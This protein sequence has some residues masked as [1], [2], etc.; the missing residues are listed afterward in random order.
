MDGHSS[1]LSLP[2]SEFC[3]DNDIVLIAL[4]PNSTHIL[5]PMDVAVFHSLKNAW[6]KKVHDWRMQNNGRRLKRCEFGPLLEDCILV[7]LKPETIQHGFRACGLFPFNPDAVNYSKLIKSSSSNNTTNVNTPSTNFPIQ[8]SP[9]T[10]TTKNSDQIVKYLEEWAGS[11]KIR[12]F[13]KCDGDWIGDVK[14]TNLYL[15]WKTVNSS[16]TTSENTNDNNF[17]LGNST[18]EA[19]F[20]DNLSDIN[21]DWS[22]V[23]DEDFIQFD[24]QKDGFLEYSSQVNNLTTKIGSTPDSQQQSVT[25]SD[26]LLIPEDLTR[27]IQ[28]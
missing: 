4:L 28:N 25:L 2:L 13:K 5:Q 27:R 20:V 9:G 21:V 16:V 3:R 17:D 11:E 15:F 7:S 26:N 18:L 22:A 14:D 8:S 23:N 12:K 1:H 10:S 6:R 24:V 19:N